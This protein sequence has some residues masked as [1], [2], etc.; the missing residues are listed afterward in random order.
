MVADPLAVL[1]ERASGAL[2]SAER[3]LLAMRCGY[4]VDIMAVALAGTL[5]GRIIEQYTLL[6]SAHR[7]PD[8][9]DPDVA[10]LVATLQHA[11]QPF[12]RSAPEIAAQ[13]TQIEREVLTALLD[14]WVGAAGVDTVSALDD[15]SFS[16][17]LQRRILSPSSAVVRVHPTILS[18][19]DRVSGEAIATAGIAA[20]SLDDLEHLLGLRPSD[21]ADYARLLASTAPIPPRRTQALF[22]DGLAE[23][24]T[25][26]AAWALVAAIH[27]AILGRNWNTPD[28]RQVP[29]HRTVGPGGRGELRVSLRS[30]GD[31][32]TLWERVSQL[33]DLT[34]DTLLV[35]LAAWTAAGGS[36]DQP[37]WVSADTIL[38]ARGIKRIRR[39]HEPKNW[40]HGHRREDRLAVGRALA[41]L[42]QLWL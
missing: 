2:G 15:T 38:D 8:G 6:R 7:Q 22:R 20:R 1:L 19:L 21:A 36:A 31:L 27:D 32:D 14:E 17:E 41:Q 34:S 40:Q 25:N 24:P 39:S 30:N 18:W 4:H 37:V 12:V 3:T 42:D 26:R 11:T 13:A 33:D 35:C 9:P 28:D 5:S 16:T 23:I 29:E 10:T